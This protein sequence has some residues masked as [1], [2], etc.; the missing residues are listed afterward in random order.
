M[1]DQ[2]QSKEATVSLLRLEKS[3]RSAGGCQAGQV[4]Q[5]SHVR[6]VT[7]PGTVVHRPERLQ[8]LSEGEGSK[9]D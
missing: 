6:E 9:V 1:I 8:Q 5:P 4:A 3:A 2:E 7:T